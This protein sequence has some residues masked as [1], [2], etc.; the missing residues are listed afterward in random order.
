AY[1]GGQAAD[2]QGLDTTITQNQFQIRGIERPLARL[3]DNGLATARIQF[4]HDV[5]ADLAAHENPTHGPVIANARLAA[6]A[7]QLRRRAISQI[8]PVAFTGMHDQHA[9]FTRRTEYA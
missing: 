1:L 3:V 7:H 6:P 8:G 9:A 4:R 5:V 2:D